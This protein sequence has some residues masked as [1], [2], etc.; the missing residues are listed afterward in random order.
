LRKEHPIEKVN[1]GKEKVRLGIE[2]CRLSTEANPNSSTIDAIG[3]SPPSPQARCIILVET[4]PIFTSSEPP[5]IVSSR[6]VVVDKKMM[7]DLLGDNYTMDEIRE[8]NSEKPSCEEVHMV[9]LLVQQ[10]DIHET[11][12]EHVHSPPKFDL[13]VI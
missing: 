8:A 1:E 11:T 13:Q 12:H 4:N 2:K 3:V 7:I 6:Q 9:K 5:M 10:L